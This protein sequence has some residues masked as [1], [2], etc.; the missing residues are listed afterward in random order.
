M[1]KLLTEEV[2]YSAVGHI[3]VWVRASEQSD[4]KGE[5]GHL[6]ISI[7]SICIIMIIIMI[8]CMMMMIIIIIVSS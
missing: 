1:G 2:M 6:M 5:V 4:D 3:G 7:I 8:I